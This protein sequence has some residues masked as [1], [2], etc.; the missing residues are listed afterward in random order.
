MSPIHTSPYNLRVPFQT[1]PFS[2]QFNIQNNGTCQPSFLL[3]SLLRTPNT[4]FLVTG[5]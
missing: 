4:E 2:T 1:I 3:F 5:M